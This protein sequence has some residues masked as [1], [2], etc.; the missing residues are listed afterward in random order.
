MREIRSSGSVEG[1]MGNRDPYSD[2]LT[3]SASIY[4]AASAITT[5][6]L[7]ID[8]APVLCS[9]QGLTDV[10][11]MSFTNPCAPF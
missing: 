5:R 4:D 8:H 10:V 3:R 6:A 9:R 11:I 2:Y 7:I 1:V